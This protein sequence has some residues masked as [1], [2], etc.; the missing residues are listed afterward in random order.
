M[1]CDLQSYEAFMPTL[2]ERG[3]DCAL[4]EEEWIIRFNG[5]IYVLIIPED[6]FQK[7]KAEIVSSDQSPGNLQEV[8]GK[9]RKED[10]A[11][12]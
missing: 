2:C 4:H 7:Q 10:Q 1:E 5:K 6:A 12:P 8:E 3:A 11:T 9:V